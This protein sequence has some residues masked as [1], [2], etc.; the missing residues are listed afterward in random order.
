MKSHRKRN[1]SKSRRRYRIKSR[2][3]RVKSRIKNRGRRRRIKT[4]SVKTWKKKRKRTVRKKIKKIKRNI[5]RSLQIHKGG[6]AAAEA[7]AVWVSATAA[8]WPLLKTGIGGATGRWYGSIETINRFLIDNVRKLIAAEGGVRKELPKEHE[9]SLKHQKEILIADFTNYNRMSIYT[10]IH[11]LNVEI[12][13]LGNVIVSGGDGFNSF[14]E[15]ILRAISPDIDVKCC[16]TTREAIQLHKLMQPG[17]EDGPSSLCDKKLDYINL[18]NKVIKQYMELTTRI[19]KTMR[20]FVDCFNFPWNGVATGETPDS[21]WF[22]TKLTT[23]LR[24]AILSLDAPQRVPWRIIKG[25]FY[26]QAAADV[27]G[28]GSFI[29]YGGN[30]DMGE[31]KYRDFSSK[32]EHNLT[33]YIQDYILPHMHIPGWG[34]NWGGAAA[35]HK[36]LCTRRREEKDRFEKGGAEGIGGERGGVFCHS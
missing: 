26:E 21:Y 34:W 27:R 3:S 15:A 13:G 10:L 6:A 4:R 31:L 23:K 14:L 19:T 28:G 18:V 1:R 2:K 35:R 12:E 16:L 11:L 22:G 9:K 36:W 17:S 29:Q 20:Y 5:G 25:L 24:D 32:N 8:D 7:A 30:S 33:T